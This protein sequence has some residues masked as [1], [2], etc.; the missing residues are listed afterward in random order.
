QREIGRGAPFDAD[1]QDVDIVPAEARTVVS[2]ERRSIGG[3]IGDG[4]HRTEPDV[5]VVGE[6]RQV[7]CEVVG[8]ASLQARW[9]I[10][11]SLLSEKTGILVEVLRPDAR[12]SG[13]AQPQGR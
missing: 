12:G 13:H 9:N 4:F 1:L 11:T 5:L 10:E 3:W 2:P 7:R 8:D 6:Q